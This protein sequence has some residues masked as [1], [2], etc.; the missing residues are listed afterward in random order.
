MYELSITRRNLS[1]SNM[2]TLRDLSDCLAYPLAGFNALN[3]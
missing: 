3:I 1:S 2:L